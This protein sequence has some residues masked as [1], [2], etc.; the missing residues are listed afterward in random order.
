MQI[1]MLLLI[2]QCGT[3]SAQSNTGTKNTLLLG[4]QR[5]FT[6]SKA[7]LIDDPVLHLSE[8]YKNYS[9]TSYQISH[10]V[11]GKETELVGPFLIKSN[12]MTIGHAADILRKVQPGDKIFLEEVVALSN[13]ANKLP[14]KLASVA[15]QVQ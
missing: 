10:V 2:T 6:I 1:L 9:I 8:A 4:K 13:D 3:V 15:I 14:L 12:A 7:T 11:K 5:S